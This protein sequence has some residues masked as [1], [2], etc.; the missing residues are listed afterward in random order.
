MSRPFIFGT[1]NY[2]TEPPRS[3]DSVYICANGEIYEA[4]LISRADSS[5]WTWERVGSMPGGTASQGAQGPKGDKGDTGDTGPAGPQGATGAQGAAGATG[6]QG[7]Q[8][9]AGTNGA[10]GAQGPAGDPLSVA[11]AWP[12]GSIF[13]SAVATN[14]ATLLGIGTWAAFG[15]GRVLV[16][17]NAS[18]T[19][20][21]TAEETGGAKTVAAAGTN[22]GPTFTGSALGTHTHDAGTL[23]P[24]AHSG[25]TVGDHSALTNNHSGVT[26]GNHSDVLNHTHGFTNLRGATTGGA[27]TNMGVTEAQDTSSTATALL[28]ANPS[29]NGVAAQVHT[30]G[31][32]TAHGAISA[33]V[34][35]Q[36]SNHTMSGTAA[37]ASGGTPAG[38]VSAPTFTGTPTSVVQPYITV[39]MFKRTA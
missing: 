6:A 29:A 16:G 1:G 26:V 12:V 28:T 18:D 9:N 31:Q 8:G 30:V 22:S 10:T 14:P 23:V 15:A 35:G 38:T 20:F 19:D 34:V 24:S 32:P 25:A 4:R 2:P 11:A 33:H 3:F 37:A 17:F 36:P 7:P 13:I 27:T 21:D 39:Y 5:S